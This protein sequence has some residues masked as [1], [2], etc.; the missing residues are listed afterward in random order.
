MQ[1]AGNVNH[2]EDLAIYAVLPSVAKAIGISVVGYEN[3]PIV[4][5]EVFGESLS[6]SAKVQELLDRR[7]GAQRMTTLSIIY[8]IDYRTRSLT[9]QKP[10]ED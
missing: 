9:N 8:I 3:L 5:V 10:Y 7:A 6:T 4:R 2:E 1:H